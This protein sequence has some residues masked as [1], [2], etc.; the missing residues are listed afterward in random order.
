M[1]S[2]CLL[3]NERNENATLS[4][5]RVSIKVPQSVQGWFI[6]E[7]LEDCASLQ[8]RLKLSVLI[9]SENLSPR[10]SPLPWLAFSLSQFTPP[11]AGPVS[12]RFWSISNKKEKPGA[13][14]QWGEG[15]C[16][17]DCCPTAGSF[18]IKSFSLKDRESHSRP[19]NMNGCTWSFPWE[20][21]IK[22]DLP[23]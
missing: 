21:H 15:K 12:G 13:E 6:Q 10:P 16:W 22:T 18:Y 23:F 8:K 14:Y 17:G 19:C 11:R 1:I 2:A 20:N 7:Q 4:Y 5:P 3:L 9:W